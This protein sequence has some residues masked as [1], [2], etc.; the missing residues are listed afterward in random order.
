MLIYK[1][2]KILFFSNE[3]FLKKMKLKFL[4][5]QVNSLY[6]KANQCVIKSLG[7]I[8]IGEKFDQ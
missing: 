7:N 2:E 3:L 5:I 6:F 4:S 1:F 8:R